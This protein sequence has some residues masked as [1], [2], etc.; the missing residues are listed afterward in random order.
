MK[1]NQSLFHLQLSKDELWDQRKLKRDKY[2]LKSGWKYY[3][4]DLAFQTYVFKKAYPDYL[5]SSYLFCP[6]KDK[7][8]SIDGLNQKFKVKEESPSNY[9]VEING[10]ISLDALGTMIMAKADLTNE[11]ELILNNKLET[12]EITQKNFTETITYLADTY[13]NDEFIAP[14]VG[15]HCKIL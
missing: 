13:R 10:D 9:K 4:L 12:F 14:Q 8:T 5:T 7:L 11:V 3:I 1:S 15:S 2:S 6:D